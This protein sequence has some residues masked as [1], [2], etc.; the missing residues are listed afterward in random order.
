[1]PIE[2]ERKFRVV[3]DSWRDGVRRVRRF[4]QAYLA[5]GELVSVRV[6]I[7]DERSATLTVKTAAAGLARSE[8][9][10]AIPLA[11]ARELIEQRQGASIEKLRHDLPMADLTWEIDVFEGLNAGLVIAEIELDH[12]ERAIELPAWV[13]EEVT[14]DRRFYNAELAVRPFSSW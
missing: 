4:S 11:D 13:G 14:H 2:I 8:Y 12:T 5:L 6:R 3:G 7:S 1:M 9:E 10:Y